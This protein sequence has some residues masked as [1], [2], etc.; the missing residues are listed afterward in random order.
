MSKIL[1]IFDVYWATRSYFWENLGNFSDR[2]P[3]FQKIG[4][5]EIEIFSQF[6]DTFGIS[7]DFFRKGCQKTKTMRGQSFS[8]DHF[9]KSYSNFSIFSG[10]R[11]PD[12]D[13]IMNMTSHPIF[14]I[15]LKVLRLLNNHTKP[16]LS[17]SV[18]MVFLGGG[19]MAPLMVNKF[20]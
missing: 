20:S 13:V 10:S 12:A 3:V 17:C 19:H 9:L 5:P 11:I 8:G 16:Q 6:F 1:H 18:S 2:I 7:N 15:F 4:N 14:Y